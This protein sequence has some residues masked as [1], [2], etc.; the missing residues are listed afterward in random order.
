MSLN[1]YENMLFNEVDKVKLFCSDRPTRIT[2]LTWKHG[3]IT[4]K[5]NVT[6]SASS[7][8]GRRRKRRRRR[9]LSSVER[10]LT[11]THGWPTVVGFF[12]APAT[13]GPIRIKNY[14]QD[15]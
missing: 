12:Y 3:F 10:N 9:G 8:A 14:E 1:T 15:H 5:P 2:S 13:A 11:R 4:F 7:S 6:D